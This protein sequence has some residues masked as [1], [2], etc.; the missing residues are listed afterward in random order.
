MDLLTDLLQQAGLQRKLLDLRRL[1]TTLALQFPCDK[2]I[3]LH[4]VTHGHIY[5]HTT[6][7]AEPLALRVGDIALMARGCN[8]SA[9][10]TTIHLLGSSRSRK[11]TATQNGQHLRP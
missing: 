3:G 8:H 5:I 10:V 9:R 11:S 6:T 1:D 4:V 7:L 2:S